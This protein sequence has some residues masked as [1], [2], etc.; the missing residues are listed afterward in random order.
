MTSEVMDL[1]QAAGNDAFQRSGT[2]PRRNTQEIAMS[3]FS[4]PRFLP[5]VLSLDAVTCAATGLIQ[6]V[7]AD[8]LAT[9]LQL[10]QALLLETGLFLIAYAGALIW[11][12][13]R[14]AVPR[15][16]VGLIAFGN[17][18]WAI[19]CIALMA[20][21]W[22]SPS[23]FGMVWIGAQALASLVMADLQWLGLRGSRDHGGL[24]MAA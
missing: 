20:G 16:G 8:A 7:G 9:L 5:R 4:S 10:P 23:T 2:G 6:L 1:I 18:A 14:A 24:A 21:P 3:F 17:L 11:M 13:S 22:I 19:A 12:A 15:K